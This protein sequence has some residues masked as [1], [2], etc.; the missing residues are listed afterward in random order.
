MGIA[1]GSRHVAAGVGAV[2]VPQIEG[3]AQRRRHRAGG[4]ARLQRFVVRAE[5]DAG[6]RSVAAE[7]PDGF[8]GDGARFEIDQALAQQGGQ[9]DGDPQ[10]G[11]LT[12]LQRE[13]PGVE[14]AP[15][16]LHQGVGPALFRGAGVVGLPSGGGQGSQSFEDHCTALGI[17]IT[18]EANHSRPHGRGVQ[19]PVL[20][21]P[22]GR[23]GRP[24]EVGQ[25]PPV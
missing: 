19:P 11:A 22:L 6:H 4:P 14:M 8:G 16:D 25:P 10:V 15:A 3:P 24:V 20:E 12:A 23:L 7:A 18:V 5:H 13:G 2:P 17:E 1:P 9:I 21:C